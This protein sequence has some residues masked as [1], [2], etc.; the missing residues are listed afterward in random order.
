[1]IDISVVIG[2][3]VSIVILVLLLAV[4]FNYFSYRSDKLKYDA[5]LEKMK[6][7]CSQCQSHNCSDC[8]WHN[9]TYY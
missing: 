4:I 2:V 5:K 3:S 8:V 1:M 9:K 7:V 6:H